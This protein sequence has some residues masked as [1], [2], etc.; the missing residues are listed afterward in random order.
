MQTHLLA[1]AGGIKLGAL[2]KRVAAFV[3]DTRDAVAGQLTVRRTQLSEMERL[4]EAQARSQRSYQAAELSITTGRRLLADATDAGEQLVGVFLDALPEILARTERDRKSWS[5]ERSPITSPKAHVLDVGAR[6]RASLLAAIEEWM[7]ETGGDV[8]RRAIEVR[9]EIASEK[10]SALR[11]YLQEAT[12]RD[13][14]AI[15]DEVRQQSL[16]ECFSGFGDIGGTG[17]ITKVATGGAL[18]LVI[19]YVVADIVLYYILGAILF[20]PT[21]VALAG[22]KMLIANA[23][24]SLD[25]LACAPLAELSPIPIGS[26]GPPS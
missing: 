22:L 7:R 26:P 5:S 16:G 21:A 24:L 1:R 25:A 19:G 8:V 14:R 10:L 17:A 18:A 13:P 2:R 6:I 23:L 20:W 9:Y 12:G 3:A 4:E 11:S 15:L